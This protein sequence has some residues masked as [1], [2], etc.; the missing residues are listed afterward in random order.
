MEEYISF[1]DLVNNNKIEE[2]NIKLNNSVRVY[3]IEGIYNEAKARIKHVGYSDNIKKIII[4][5]LKIFGYESKII[6]YALTKE[7]I[8]IMKNNLKM[9]SM[10]LYKNKQPI[11]SL[12]FEFR[13][14]EDIKVDEIINGE[15]MNGE[16]IIRLRTNK[17][18]V[19]DIYT[20]NKYPGN[21]NIV[22]KLI[23]CLDEPIVYDN[24]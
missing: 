7:S 1:N 13:T 15:K 23:K 4:K 6:T 8:E 9:V 14:N 20:F 11:I 17:D 5:E 2:E 19:F 3:Q 21:N 18:K 22:E 24:L 12:S 10:I 16:F